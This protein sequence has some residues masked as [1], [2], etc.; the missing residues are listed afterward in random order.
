MRRLIISIVLALTALALAS[1]PVVAFDG[2]CCYDGA[3][4]QLAG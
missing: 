3:T 1:G 4:V 2:P